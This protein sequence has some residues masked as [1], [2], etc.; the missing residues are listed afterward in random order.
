M[1]FV[2]AAVRD[3]TGGQ[4]AILLLLLHLQESYRVFPVNMDVISW[5]GAYYVK[6]E[7]GAGQPC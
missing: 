3:V 7:V 1:H 4:T 2:S 5:L 6:S